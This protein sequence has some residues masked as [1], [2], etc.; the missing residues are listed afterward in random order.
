MVHVKRTSDASLPFL[1]CAAVVVWST[2]LY[3]AHLRLRRTNVHNNRIEMLCR[4]SDCSDAPPPPLAAARGAAVR[5][6][7]L[8]MP[9]SGNPDDEMVLH[10]SPDDEPEFASAERLSPMQAARCS[11]RKTFPLH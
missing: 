6:D 2:M 10:D 3:T 11:S 7:D 5:P 4:R 8:V 1:A 9:S